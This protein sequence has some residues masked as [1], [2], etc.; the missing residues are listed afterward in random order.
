MSLPG[1]IPLWNNIKTCNEFIG[2][3]LH[4]HELR[5]IGTVILRWE[6]QGFYKIFQEG[7]HVIAGESLPWQIISELPPARSISYSLSVPL[8]VD[9]KSFPKI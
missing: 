5:S 2:I 6:G 9:A 1:D 4:G 8:V 7:F 3:C